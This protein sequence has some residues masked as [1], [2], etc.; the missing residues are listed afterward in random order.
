MPSRKGL[1]Q[2]VLPRSSTPSGPRRAIQTQDFHLGEFAVDRA[3]K[4][5]A[6][7][8]CLGYTLLLRVLPGLLYGHFEPPLVR[9]NS[10]GTILLGVENQ[11]CATTR[12]WR[13]WPERPALCATAS[14]LRVEQV[15][16]RHGYHLDEI[17]AELGKLGG[18]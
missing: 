18:L 5:L 16:A 2:I 4:L 1:R 7:L 8:H 6:A 17:V 3:H 9:P 10:L 13:S 12:L 11:P 15:D 14:P